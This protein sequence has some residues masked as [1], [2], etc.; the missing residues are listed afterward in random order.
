MEC[1]EGYQG[2]KVGFVVEEETVFLV[3]IGWKSIEAHM[4]W[5]NTGGGRQVVDF[6][7]K[8][9]TKSFEMVHISPRGSIPSSQ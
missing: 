4:N 3:L 2:H 8:G 6:Y 7:I 9:G 5:I 1:A